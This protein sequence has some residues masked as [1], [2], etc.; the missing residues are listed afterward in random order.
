MNLTG[1]FSFLF[2]LGENVILN[3][4][5]FQEIRGIISKRK[6]DGLWCSDVVLFGH[7]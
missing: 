7:Y 1:P 3:F 6:L 4:L 5:K 2:C